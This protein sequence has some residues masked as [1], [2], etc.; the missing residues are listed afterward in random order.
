MIDLSALK[1]WL[2]ILL[3][4]IP[5]LIA[6]IL[7]YKLVI[8]KKP[9]IG[10]GILAGLGAIGAFLVHRKLKKAFAVE[11]KLSEFNE[12]YAHFKEIQKR[13]QEAV[14]ANQQVIKV[15]EDRKKKLAQ[16]ADKYQTELQLIDAE[17]KDRL[18][19]NQKLIEDAESFMTAAQERSAERKKLLSSEA[20]KADEAKFTNNQD[21]QVDGYQ[22]I[23][24]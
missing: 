2:D 16:N 7:V 20:P 12:N 14:T 9:K 22:L 18:A 1:V 11:D 3:I 19:L 5:F 10:L 13:R 6:M 8:P 23:E 21:L 24:E 17:L 4:L 15:L